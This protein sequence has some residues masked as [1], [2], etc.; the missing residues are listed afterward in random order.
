MA[1]KD[2]SEL[3]LHQNPVETIATAKSVALRNRGKVFL[4]RFLPPMLGFSFAACQLRQTTP[5]Q[6]HLFG[7]D[8]NVERKLPRCAKNFHLGR[9]RSRPAHVSLRASGI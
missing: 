1:A 4:P 2:T 8:G 7:E 6:V 5:N 3:E 9:F